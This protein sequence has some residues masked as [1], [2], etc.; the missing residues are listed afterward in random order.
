MALLA[1]I[2]VEHV[3][4]VPSDQIVLMLLLQEGAEK[5]H[6]HVNLQLQLMWGQVFRDPN[7]PFL[8]FTQTVQQ[9]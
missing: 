6:A 8:G 4:P 1:V 2:Y 3:L 7:A 5:I 9:L